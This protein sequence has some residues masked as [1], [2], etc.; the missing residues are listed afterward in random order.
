M[1]LRTALEGVGV[2]RVATEAEAVALI[3]Q[4]FA[5]STSKGQTFGKGREELAAVIGG[6]EYSGNVA[7]NANG[8]Q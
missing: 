4:L 5:L 7:A 2:L 8:K 1:L 6:V 3:W